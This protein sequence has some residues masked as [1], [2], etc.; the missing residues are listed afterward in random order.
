[1]IAPGASGLCRLDTITK[2]KAVQLVQQSCDIGPD[3]RR[4]AETLYPMVQ[5][6][7]RDGIYTPRRGS[8]LCSRGYCGYWRECE[9]EFG[10]RVAERSGN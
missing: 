5:E 2:T 10:G 3:E 8:P 1:M 6:A 7:M 4:Y 9:L